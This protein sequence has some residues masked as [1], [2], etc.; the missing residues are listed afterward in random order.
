LGTLVSVS[1]LVGF[2]VTMAILSS[3]LQEPTKFDV[4][5]LGEVAANCVNNLS[6]QTEPPLSCDTAAA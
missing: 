3:E 5:Q 6:K 4:T 1:T 2:G